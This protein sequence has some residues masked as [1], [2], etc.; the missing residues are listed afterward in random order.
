MAAWDPKC[1]SA[2]EVFTMTEKV[3]LL[4]HH[5]KHTYVAA[6]ITSGNME[7]MGDRIRQLRESRNWTQAELA[8]RVH[9]TRA[10]ISQWERGETSNIKLATFLSLCD[11]FDTSPEYLVF[12]P[13]SNTR[14]QD[15]RFRRTR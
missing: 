14:G 8:N 6:G 2:S 9:V 7:T 1:C 11:I 3:S 12:G 10:A 4:A 15:G 13:G 5:V